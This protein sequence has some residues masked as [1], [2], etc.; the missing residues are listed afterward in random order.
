MKN[1]QFT[2]TKALKLKSFGIP[3][4][5]LNFLLTLLE[6]SNY[7]I[8][9]PYL[10]YVRNQEEVILHSVYDLKRV[11]VCEISPMPEDSFIAYTVLSDAFVLYIVVSTA[12]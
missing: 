1:T 4:S 6:T 11:F 8:E 7:C 3:S 12:D 9:W 5:V 10:C 2:N